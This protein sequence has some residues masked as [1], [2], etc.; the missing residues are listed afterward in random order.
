MLGLG[1]AASHAPSMFRPAEY[2]PEIHRVLTEGVPQPREIEKETPQVLREYVARVEK[3]FETLKK[4]FERYRPDA[5]VVIGDDQGEVFSPARTPTFCIFTCSEVRGSL[6]IG[7][8]KEPEEE[9][10]VT[11]GCHRELALYLRD[12]LLSR[13]FDLSSIDEVKPEGKPKRGMGHAFT[14]PVVHVVPE[15]DVPT[16][17]IHVNAYFPPLPSAQR[18]YE[19]GRAIAQAL[20]G[21][22]EKV[23][24]LASGGLSHDPRGP[25]AGWI[26]TALDRWVLQQLET[27][28]GKELCHLFRFDSDS[29]SGGTGEI[30]AW[31][32]VAGA[33][34]GRKATIVDY[35]PAYHA[36]TGLGFAYWPADQVAASRND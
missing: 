16:I 13:G 4:Q 8:V 19:F 29:L 22:K 35:I 17:N 24:I 27:G 1:L 12:A 23:A 5:L 20:E 9:N 32:V 21:R 3:G 34:A 25:R 10:H 36:V 15:L 6:N 18:C 26:D 7:L 31:I 30:R 14:R 28:N 11:I 33:C 2:W